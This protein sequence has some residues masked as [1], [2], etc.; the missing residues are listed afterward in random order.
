MKTRNLIVLLA[1]AAIVSMSSCAGTF[2]TLMTAKPTEGMGL[3]MEGITLIAG[4]SNVTS[5]L[6]NTFL[7]NP[8]FWYRGVPV[9]DFLEIGGRL[10]LLSASA[11]VKLI[12]LNLDIFAIAADVEV[13]YPYLYY[14]ASSFTLD[15]A[16]SVLLTLQ[17]IS[18]FSITL[19]PKYKLSMFAYHLLGGSAVI[20]L[21]NTENFALL[22]DVSYMTFLPGSITTSS[23]NVIS[24]SVNSFLNTVGMLSV[25]VGLQF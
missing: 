15:L 14:G 6:S 12:P 10:S 24:Q 2:S 25:A 1:I 3:A 22:L 11:D 21:F 5:A 7:P 20:S 18:F 8:T 9:K 17:P 4:L 23:T 13:S 16:A 19:S